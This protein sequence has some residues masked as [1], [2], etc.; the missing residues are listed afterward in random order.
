MSR[1]DAWVNRSLYPY[2]SRFVE[3]DG[4]RT[5]H[6]DAFGSP[7]EREAP[8]VLA[9]ALVRSTAW[10]E[11]LRREREQIVGKPALALWG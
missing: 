10:Y 9:R 3:V 5:H 11:R 7:E 8:W 6:V 1:A 4:G 2:R